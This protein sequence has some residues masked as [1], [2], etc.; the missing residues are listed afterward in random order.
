MKEAMALL[1]YRLS[2]DAVTPRRQHIAVPQVVTSSWPQ[3]WQDGVALLAL[4]LLVLAF[5]WRLIT[6]D[7][8]ERQYYVNGDFTWKEQ[9]Q[10]TIGARSWAAG[11]LPLWNPTI[12]GGQPIA[13][14]SGSGVFYPID[15]LFDATA[16]AAGVSILRLEWRVVIDYLLATTLAYAFFRRVG[17]AVAP[18]LGGTVLYTFGG[19][20]TSYPPHQ[21]DILETGTWLPLALLAVHQVVS[22]HSRARRQWAMLGGL[23]LGLTFLA[24]H[25]QTALYVVYATAAYL[26]Y[27]MTVRQI[28]RPAL[29]EAGVA[30]V[31]ALGVSAI[32]LVPSLEF[33]PL[34]NR[35]TIPDAAARVGLAVPSL[36][37]LI[38]PHY[39][40]QAALYV[41]AGGLLLAAFGTW[42]RWRS[43]GG[44]WCGLGF[45][46]LLLGLGGQTPLYP[47][48]AH[49]GLGLVRDQSRAVFLTSFAAATLATLGLAEVR[50]LS[51]SQAVLLLTALA[52]TAG[53]ATT[54]VLRHLG[55]SLAGGTRDSPP[56]LRLGIG[57]LVVL[58]VLAARHRQRGWRDLPILALVGLLAVDGM[59]VNWN[60]NLT[61]DP[62][63]VD[64]GL[65]G[66]IR[67]LHTLP[68]P[69]RI[70][71]DGDGLIPANDL[72]KFD[73]ATDQGYNDFRLAAV[74]ELLTST[75][76]WRAWQLLD[77]HEFLTTRTFSSP[78]VLQQTE[79]GV[80]TYAISEM[81]PDVWAVW[82]YQVTAASRATLAAVLAPGFDPGQEV[83]L[84]QPPDLTIPPLP[85]HAQQVTEEVQSAQAV[86]I[87]AQV[88]QAAILI[89]SS[90]YYPGW[91][92]TVD[93]RRAPLLRADHALQAVAIPAGRHVV[94][95]TFD[96]WSVKIGA[97]VT[98]LTVLGSMLGLWKLGR[99]P[100]AS[101]RA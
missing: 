43:G 50:R 20:L 30:T 55:D 75:N 22:A 46:A 98:M 82:Q 44:F 54:L 6:P 88:D 72:G 41:G 62:P 57:I 91:V 42:R 61:R 8:A 23:A 73:L 29:I 24:G 63:A 1:R 59:A 69:F 81:L 31:V 26:V 7:V 14:D 11:Q 93:G 10:D 38:L 87:T 28:W 85:Q 39:A 95:F 33:F 101:R 45:A 90:A 4:W 92:V 27:Q 83:V 97:G 79:H 49:L 77:V 18:A 47:I 12:Y 96:P 25:P 78:Y 64:D 17:G 40:D 84:D 86:T 65:P 67:F 68:Q 48:F 99:V 58:A 13:A 71:T 56:L 36:P 37:G 66:T 5:F 34:S 52:V 21:L 76:L 15:I 32:Q 60:N 3:H 53:S 94:S 35:T 16:G 89:R 9:A 19:Y 2:A 51:Q 80:H 100:A 74:D 70:A